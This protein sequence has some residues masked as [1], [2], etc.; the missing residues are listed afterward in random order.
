MRDLFLP[1]RIVPISFQRHA[2]V[3]LAQYNPSN[4]CGNRV[5]DLLKLNRIYRFRANP[6]FNPNPNWI[7]RFRGHIFK[8]VVCLAPDG[9][10]PVP[11]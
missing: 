2:Y 5:L 3:E 1:D 10:S 8:L 4:A 7:Y 9:L 11:R 6:K